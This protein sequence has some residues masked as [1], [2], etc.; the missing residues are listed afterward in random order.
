M[1]RLE[2]LTIGAS[3]TGLRPKQ[4]VTVVAANWHGS[5]T[6]DLTFKDE[7]GNVGNE[8]LFRDAES[9]LEVSEQIRPW[10]FDAPADRFK[11]GLEAYRISLASLFDPVLAVHTSL[12][13]PL[14]HQILAVYEAMLPVQPLRF[15][16]ADDPGAGKTI[17]A[18]LLIKELIARGDVQ[19]CLI[20]C[21]GSLGE[22][23]QDE[24]FE[25]FSLEFE[26]ATNDKL[27]A[28]RS[29]NWFSETDFCI[30]RIDK[31]ARDDDC[32]TMLKQCDWDL[33]IVDEAHKMSASYFGNE[34]KY[35]KRYRLGQLVSGTTR[36]FLLMTAT[37]HNGKEEDFQLF[38]ALLDGDRFEGKFRDGVHV[39]DSR[40]LM[41]RLT[42]E[43]LLRFDGSPLF[44]ERRA[45]VVQYDLSDDES[46]LYRAVTDYVRNEFNRAEQLEDGGRKGTVGFALT[47]LQRRLASSPD[48]I[49]QSL[50]RRKERLES[51][52]REARE[53]RRG[54]GTDFFQ[55]HKL[56]SLSDEDLDDI[57]EMP[58]EEVENLE[59]TLVHGATSAQTIAEL[60]T[61]IGMLQQLEEM[62]DV[63]RKSGSD[64]KW[65]ELS[66][67]LQDNENMFDTNGQR[68][69]LVVFTEHKDTLNY[70]HRQIESLIGDPE[71]IVIISGGM[72]RDQRRNAEEA[73][74]SNPEV[75]VLLATDAAGEGINLQRGHLMVNYDLPWNPNRLEQRFGR[76]H[77]IGQT[78]VCHLWNL[79]AHNTREGDVYER[80]LEKLDTA[81]EALGGSVFDVLGRVFS[82]RDLREL[83]ME[84]VR[85]GDRDDVKARLLQTVDNAAS[86]E[87]IRDLIE[88]E[89]LSKD[90]MDSRRVQRVREEM[91]RQELMRLQPH[92][93]QQ[94]FTA[95][96]ESL[97][98]K[99]SPREAGR[100]EITHVPSIIRARDRQIGRLAP[101]Q[102]RYERVTFEKQHSSSKVAFLCP[103]HPLLDATLSVVLEQNRPLLRHGAVLINQLDDSLVPK[104]LVAL[105]HRMRD[106]EPNAQGE[107]RTISREVQFVLIDAEGNVAAAGFAPHID[108]RAPT[109]QELELI[110]GLADESWLTGKLEES[111]STYALQHIVPQHRERVEKERRERLTRTRAAVR[112][113]LLH[114]INHWDSRTQDLKVKEEAGKYGKLNS[115][116][117]ERRAEDLQ[118]RLDAR[119]AEIDRQMQ[120][121]TAMPNVQAGALVVPIGL[122]NQRA[123]ERGQPVQSHGNSLS[124][125]DNAAI[126]RLAMEAVM[127]AESELGREP[128]AMAHNNPGYDIESHVL[129]KH[130][131]RTGKL[132]FIEVKGKTVGKETVTISANQIN[133]SFN[134]PDEFV[135][136]IVPVENGMA[137]N[138]RYIRRPFDQSPSGQIQS[139]NFKLTDLLNRS[140]DAC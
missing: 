33:V 49:F 87:R 136:A 27:E 18:G 29:G 137:N 127:N 106:S 131:A 58:E 133:W 119:L 13:E 22:Q 17:M 97:G 56:P 110:S 82:G 41:R 59:A 75:Q 139:C 100:Y 50:R 92:Y 6:V 76:I 5:D 3:V 12:V 21:P 140:T 121:S 66:S 37:P 115:T 103:G 25:K 117:A 113:R 35:T 108:Y 53:L 23:W 101:V 36:H 40:D 30:G 47:V 122:I 81:R 94:F 129:D 80:L 63:V 46:A 132:F 135:L 26:I 78:E 125:A 32:Q 38:M 11:L 39:A 79:V 123:A 31:L 91:E 20:I 77:R 138:P 44:P 69:K 1:A 54:G 64:T 52:L 114:E 67:L 51:Q 48:A 71:A 98:G 74:R 16:L 62:A 57:E 86:Q 65:A 85:Y 93:I 130:G 10:S 45:Y 90:S 28:A 95:A 84:A 9:R 128:V 60:E 8:V 70:L 134:K 88:S 83:M 124:S 15:L 89:A 24:L 116:H 4:T 107:P 118:A 102:P 7:S 68:R 111:A 42:K 109:D 120:I 14:P 126:D 112:Q 99:L 105:D 61:E 34:V 72:G 96:F 55:K 104:A 73:F 43:Q 2:D 19:R